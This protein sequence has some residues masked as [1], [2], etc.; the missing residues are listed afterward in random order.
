MEQ[1]QRA[2]GGSGNDDDDGNM[3][4]RQS[5]HRGL[6]GLLQYLVAAAAGAAAAVLAAQT[7]QTADGRQQRGAAVGPSWCRV[8]KAVWLVASIRWSSA[9]GGSVGLVPGYLAVPNHT[10]LHLS[11]AP[12]QDQLHA[13]F[14]SRP[15]LD[16]SLFFS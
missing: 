3:A 11:A 1:R 8:P 9:A 6:W 14:P 7:R 4:V 5:G 16:P 10:S 2:R 15:P 13:R 12:P